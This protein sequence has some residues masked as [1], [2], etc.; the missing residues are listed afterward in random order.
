MRKITHFLLKKN[1][2][3]QRKREREDFKNLPPSDKTLRDVPTKDRFVLSLCRQFD[4][5]LLEGE[6]VLLCFMSARG[7]Y[8]MPH[9]IKWPGPNDG[10]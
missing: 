8:R 10:G 9:P 2:N 3:R 6:G 4:P 5:Y 1:V 7:E